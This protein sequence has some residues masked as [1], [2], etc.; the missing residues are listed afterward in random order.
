LISTFELERWVQIWGGERLR[1]RRYQKVI[2][3][4]ML[5]VVVAPLLLFCGC[6]VTQDRDVRV[7]NACL[8][9]HPNETA[10]CEAPRQAYQPD[11]PTVAARSS[12]GAAVSQ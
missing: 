4:K 8:L 7:Y 1:S 2:P 9:R 5:F 12:P 11:V 10:L 3:M 6:T